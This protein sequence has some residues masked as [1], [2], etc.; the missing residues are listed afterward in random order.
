MLCYGKLYIVN[1]LQVLGE[2]VG[3]SVNSC[4]LPYVTSLTY[5]AA[6]LMQKQQ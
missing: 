3:L 1:N 6:A 2:G 5:K 4:I